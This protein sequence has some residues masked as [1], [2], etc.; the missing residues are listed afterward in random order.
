MVSAQALSSSG[1]LN[2]KQK[3]IVSALPEQKLTSDLVVLSKSRSGLSLTESMLKGPVQSAD[4]TPE[5]ASLHD[6]GTKI[7]GLATGSAC[8]ATSGAPIAQAIFEGLKTGFVSGYMDPGAIRSRCLELVKKYPD[9]VELVDTG[10]KSHGYD[11]KREDLRG[12]APLYYLRLGP[13][14]AGRDEKVGV[15]QHSSPH[16]REHVNS[17]TM[18]ELAEQLCANYDPK[19]TDPA[20]QANTRLLDSLDIYISPD[21]N[22]D[23]TNY[24]FYDDR[25]WRKNRAPFDGVDAGVDVNRN[26]PYKW[27][28]SRGPNYQTY[29]GKQP[30]SEPETKAM[31][32]VV[33][34]HPNIKFVVD[35]HSYSEEVRRPLGVSKEDA[36][37][38]DKFHGRIKEAIASSRGRQYGVVESKVVE[39]A[40]DDYWYHARGLYSTI[41]ETARS[42]QPTESEALAVSSECARGAREVLEVAADYA[43][44]GRGLS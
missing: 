4:S 35:W 9:L 7:S 37:F 5:L 3:A 39:G 15:Y 41:I 10:F 38:Y 17:I 31:I 19:S 28:A 13:R 1:G 30:A 29:P 25:N 6:M 26:Y 36:A 40:S 8:A 12:P 24:S 18:L 32:S 33:D 21:T 44:L 16:A 14:T 11:G 22:P 34:S 20:I 23:G 27:Q 42:F 43:E 2:A